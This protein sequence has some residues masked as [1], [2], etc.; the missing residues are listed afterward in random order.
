[1]SC[2]AEGTWEALHS[3][4]QVVKDAEGPLLRFSFLTARCKWMCCLHVEHVACIVSTMYRVYS[5]VQ[6]YSPVWRHLS[7]LQGCHEDD[8]P[9]CHGPTHSIGGINVPTYEAAI[10]NHMYECMC[11]FHKVENNIVD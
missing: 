8:V 5:T 11:R 10:R 9:T 3:C 1:M 6:L 4:D 7:H 2:T